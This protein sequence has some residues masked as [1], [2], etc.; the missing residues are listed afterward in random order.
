MQGVSA[1]YLT[2]EYNPPGNV[3]GEFAYAFSLPVLPRAQTYTDSLSFFQRQCSSLRPKSRH[4]LNRA[5]HIIYF[6]GERVSSAIPLF[7]F[8]WAPV[9]NPFCE[10]VASGCLHN[11]LNGIHRYFPHHP[12]RE[13]RRLS[14]SAWSAH[15]PTAVGLRLIGPW[16]QLPLG[17]EATDE[18]CSS[19]GVVGAGQ[20][21]VSPAPAISDAKVRRQS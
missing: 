18:K 10:L 17:S 13:I 21:G 11:V 14:P 4:F 19:S 8:G 6:A 16:S 5:K 20:T 1:Q 12:Q 3:I 2:C 9:D 7:V 15:T